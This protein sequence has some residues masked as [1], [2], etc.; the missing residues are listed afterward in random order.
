MN[1][2]IT[3][4]CLNVVILVSTMFVIHK[5]SVAQEPEPQRP[6]YIEPVTTPPPDMKQRI[7]DL[8]SIKE[9]YELGISRIESHLSQN[10]DGTLQLTVE[11]AD[12]LGID[13]VV[14]DELRQALS[15]T[16]DLI[17]Q[18]KI[19][20]EQVK[21][22]T[23]FNTRADSLSHYTTL[24]CAGRSGTDYFWWGYVVYMN[25]CQTQ[26]LIGLLTAGAGAATICAVLLTPAAA[27]C[28]I[29]AGLAAIGA[30]AL[31]ALTGAGGNRG[32]YTVY[33][34][35]GVQVYSWHQ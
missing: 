34:Y 21:L 20:P 19:R 2:L 4:L 16:N 13:P 6:R 27:P 12:Q 29:A 14:F 3:R 32:I 30:G 25:E 9:R 1:K 18:G 33:I 11:N 23:D 35:P 22:R 26:V 5:P 15:A 17:Q 10:P 24:S 8:R 28:G 7:E 31:V